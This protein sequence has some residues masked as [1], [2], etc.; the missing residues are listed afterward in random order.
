[1]YIGRIVMVGQTPDGRLCAGYRVS[2][3]SFPNRPA[4]LAADKVSVVPRVGHESDI[5]KNP[6]IAYNCV[7]IV[8]DGKIAVATNGS[9]TDPIAE[10]IAMGMPIRDALASCSLAMAF[11]KDQ[12]NTPRVSAVV[13][14][15][16]DATVF[17]VSI[18]GVRFPSIEKI[19]VLFGNSQMTVKA[20]SSDGT[21]ILVEQPPNG[22][23]GSGLMNVTV[24]EVLANSS[25]GGQ[26]TLVNGF[27]YINNPTPPGGKAPM[28]CAPGGPA[29][30]SSGGDWALIAGTLALLT[31]T[32]ARRRWAK[33]QH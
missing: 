32:A 1:M 15:R 10:K 17:P 7:R 18:Q 14:A 31:G 20:V 5:L 8:R 12:Y 27:E 16:G 13:P 21:S 29:S 4:V 19:R 26:D 23:P 6:Y 9:Q 22:M 33:Q 24:Q 25:I 2:S 11:E 30:G 28:I 3:R